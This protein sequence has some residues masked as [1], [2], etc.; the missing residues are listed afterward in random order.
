MIVLTER[1]KYTPKV[2]PTYIYICICVYIY[3]RICIILLV[4]YITMG[5]C[6]LLYHYHE[7]NDE[8]DDKVYDEVNRSMMRS[9]M[10][11]LM[12]MMMLDDDDDDDCIVQLLWCFAEI[13]NYATILGIQRVEYLA[14]NTPVTPL[15]WICSTWMFYPWKW[16][17]SY[18]IE[19]VNSLTTV[20][21]FAVALVYTEVVNCA[22]S[23]RLC[24]A[25]TATR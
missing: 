2:P 12:L 22:I 3:I 23:S 7:V 6:L 5:K 15:Q 13:F 11:L 21:L 20:D 9:R 25:I 24:K 8:V 1:T 19:W 16:W 14:K 17:M 4:D 10:M 18:Q